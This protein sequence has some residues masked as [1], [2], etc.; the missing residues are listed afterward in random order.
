V[1]AHQRSGS[2]TRSPDLSG[3]LVNI[4]SNEVWLV[5]LYRRIDQTDPDLCSAARAVHQRGEL[6]ETQ[7][8]HKASL[9]Q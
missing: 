3:N 7:G 2:I 6:D 4:G 9:P 8:A 5:Q 1:R